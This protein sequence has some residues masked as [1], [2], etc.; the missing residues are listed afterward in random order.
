MSRR[1]ATAGRPDENAV[2][3]VR[4]LRHIPLA[5]FKLTIAEMKVV[6]FLIGILLLGVAVKQWRAEH[7]KAPPRTTSQAR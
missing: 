3:G 7:P 6:A 4:L 5:M 2:A 1:Q